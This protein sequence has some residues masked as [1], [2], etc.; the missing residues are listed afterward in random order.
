[1]ETPV[2]QLELLFEK[3]K[4]YGTTTYELSKLKAVETTA[5]ITTSL[6]S[7]MVVV[8]FA[9]IFL[10]ILSTG[11]SFWLG[12]LLGKIY[13]G[14]FAVAA[15]YLVI[16]LILHFYLHK[17]IKKPLSDSIVSQALQ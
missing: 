17:W 2:R 12:E 4:A 10:I 7:R 8:A 1:M 6:V 16:S 14:F 13:Y 3:A 15:F 11:V 5:T 9:A